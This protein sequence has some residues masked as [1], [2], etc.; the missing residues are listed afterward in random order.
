MG[1]FARDLGQVNGFLLTLVFFLTPICYPTENLPAAALAL[2]LFTL[3]VLLSRFK[4]GV[5]LMTVNFLDVMIIDSDTVSFLLT[6]FPNLWSM[7]LLSAAVV[8]PAIGLLWWFDP[9]RVR[10]K[11]ALAG[12]VASFAL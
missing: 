9:F 4:H 5:L 8:V 6:V 1:L 3:I 11:M 7:V 12:A 10:A 2:M